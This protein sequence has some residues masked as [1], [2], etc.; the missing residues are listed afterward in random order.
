MPPPPPIDYTQPPP[1][2]VLDDFITKALTSTPPE[3]H[4]FFEAFGNLYTRKCVR[5][6]LAV[7]RADSIFRLWHQL[8]LKLSDFLDDPCSKPFR[9]DVFYYFVRDFESKL[10]QQRLVEMATK[11][12]KELDSKIV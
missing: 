9:V 5:G 2:L 8:S 3:L 12:S 10:N 7:F 11:V 1:K 6:C 4:P